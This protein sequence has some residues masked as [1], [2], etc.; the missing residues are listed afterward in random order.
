M[1]AGQMGF[2]RLVGAFLLSRVTMIVLYGVD[3]SYMTA[4]QLEGTGKLAFAHSASFLLPIIATGSIV[5]YFEAIGKELLFL[6]ASTEVS[7]SNH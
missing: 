2:S 5:F 6:V 4:I 3:I 1:V 7:S